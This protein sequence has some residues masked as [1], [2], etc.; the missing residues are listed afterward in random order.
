MLW[1]PSLRNAIRSCKIGL[2]T[3]SAFSEKDK[4][5]LFNKIVKEE[6]IYDFTVSSDANNLIRL[7]LHKD[8]ERRIPPEQIPY[9]PWFKGLN[10]KDFEVGI[11]D[12][13]FKPDKVF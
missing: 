13:P 12:P 4:K 2:F 7:L 9:H 6:P 11:V 10:F 8:P 1:E 5:K 3:K